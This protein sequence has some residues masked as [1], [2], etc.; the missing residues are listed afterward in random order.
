MALYEGKPNFCLLYN[1]QVHLARSTIPEPS[2]P[3]DWYFES[4]E[5]NMSGMGFCK[6]LEVINDQLI[7]AYC[8]S[9]GVF[10]ATRD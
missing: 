7:I 8:S 5:S 3:G 4:V 2:M 10:M 6:D 1:D 9:E